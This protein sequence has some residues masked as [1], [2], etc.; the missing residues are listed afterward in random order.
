M[1]TI[2]RFITEL[3][4]A[5]RLWLAGQAKRRQQRR[6]AAE[7]VHQA[8]DQHRPGGDVHTAIDRLR[9]R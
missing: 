2:I 1:M 3:M 4:A 9:Q 8:I 5:V 6:K 7:D